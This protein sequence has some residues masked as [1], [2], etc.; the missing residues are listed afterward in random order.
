M[1]KKLTERPDRLMHGIARSRYFW[2]C[3]HNIEPHSLF[4]PG[5]I[6]FRAGVRHGK[7]SRSKKK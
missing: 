2:R 6:K 4:T 1:K 7:A 5:R 3:M